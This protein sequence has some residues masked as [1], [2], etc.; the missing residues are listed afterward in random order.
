M[1]RILPAEQR[2]KY[3]ALQLLFLTT[4]LIQVAGAASLAPFIALL[5][6]PAVIHSNAI[7]KE[8]YLLLNCTSDKQFLM[9]FAV[10]VMQLIVLSNATA[11]LSTWLMFH[12]TSKLGSEIQGATYKSYLSKDFVFYGRNN[13][14]QMINVLT[15]EIPRY[16]FMVL[17]PFLVLCSQGFIGILILLGLIYVDAVLSLIVA[18][19]I[20]GSYL[21]VFK[22]LKERL[23]RHGHNLWLVGNQKLKLINESLGGIKEIRLLGTEQSY[24]NKLDQANVSILRSQALLGLASDLPRFIIETFAFCA[25]LGLALYLLAKHG[26][27]TEV[28]SILSLYAMAG[29]KLLPA[30]Q[31]IYKSM[32]QIK[33]NGG[34]LNE[35]YAD[36][37]QGRTIQFSQEGDLQDTHSFQGDL[38]FQNVH[39]KY[40]ESSNDALHQ[41]DLTIPRNS[42]VALVG[43]SG[44]GK[45]TLADMILGMIHPGSG[46]LLAGST[47]I[48]E[49]NVKEW[50]RNLGYVPQNIFIIDDT[51]L[52]N[53]AFGVPAEKADLSHAANAAKMANLA[54]FIESLPEKYQYHVGERGALLSGG[55]RQRLGIARA[56]YHDAKILILDEATSALDN[57]TEAEVIATINSLKSRKTII[58]IAHR[59]STIKAADLIVVMDNGKIVDTGTF[60]E[61]SNSSAAFR[62][63]LH[64]HKENPQPSIVDSNN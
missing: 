1:H 38:I 34:A 28:I 9:Y 25:L 59:L 53:I 23:S 16:V 64:L 21:L 8:L 10:G 20:G 33:A 57:V 19:V 24:A 41:I 40:P 15:Q 2:K 11:A 5:S 56:L 58:M 27:S 44:A 32:S 4:A 61:L 39:Y 47:K 22:L 49:T 13:S 36:A 54:T 46:E 26:N 62:N 55:Q 52:A 6:N 7:T 42:I 45:S 35:F 12:F 17:Q 48:T 29:Y 30:A 50:Q 18:L 31:A 14:S 63:M 3:I 60:S 37:L 43:V 51:I